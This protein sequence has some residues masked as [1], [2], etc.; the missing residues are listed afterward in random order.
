MEKVN[1]NNSRNQEEVLTSKSKRKSKRELPSLPVPE[2][3]ASYIQEDADASKSEI[4]L[5]PDDVSGEKELKRKSK[6]GKSKEATEAKA[7]SQVED[8]EDKL[9]HEFQ[10]QIVQQEERALQRTKVKT[11]EES[12]VSQNVTLNNDVGKKKKKKL[13]SV[14]TQSDEGCVYLLIRF[15]VDLLVLSPCNNKDIGYSF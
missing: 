11:E 5:K 9:L 3:A 6:K 4:A 14:I 7:E 2:D 13:K 15:S 8:A 1:I 10:Q 12:F